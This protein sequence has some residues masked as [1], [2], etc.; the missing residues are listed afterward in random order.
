MYS[1]L[2]KSVFNLLVVGA[3]DIDVG[4]W[5]DISVP[6]PPLD[7]G[8]WPGHVSVCARSP[9]VYSGQ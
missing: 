5:E 2:Y 3:G 6:T 4:Q 1:A 7:L 9:A 8:T